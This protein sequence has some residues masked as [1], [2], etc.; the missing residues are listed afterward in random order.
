[1]LCDLGSV[2][3]VLIVVGLVGFCVLGWF[4]LFVWDFGVGICCYFSDLCDCGCYGCVV[5]VVLRVSLRWV[6]GWCLICR[7]KFIFLACG[8]FGFLGLVVCAFW[9][10]CGLAFVCVLK[11]GL[12]FR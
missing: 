6:C 2:V 3:L 1:M 5:W 4:R 12:V 11:C 8:C 9:F 10:F 7:F